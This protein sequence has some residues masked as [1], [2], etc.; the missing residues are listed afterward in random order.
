MIDQDTNNDL[1]SIKKQAR[2]VL[3]EVANMQGGNP[4][5]DSFLYQMERANQWIAFQ[6][7]QIKE[8]ELQKKCDMACET[9]KQQSH[10][11]VLQ[12]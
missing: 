8:R 11:E 7:N 3:R 10:V 9:S 5:K 4:C 2:I 1:V 12:Q 6:I